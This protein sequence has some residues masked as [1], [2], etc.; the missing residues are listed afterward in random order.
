ME[1]LLGTFLPVAFSNMLRIPSVCHVV[2]SAFLVWYPCSMTYDLLV[3]FSVL[4]GIL[5]PSTSELFFDRVE[6]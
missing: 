2:S 3:D 6:T 4:L 1:I 5:S